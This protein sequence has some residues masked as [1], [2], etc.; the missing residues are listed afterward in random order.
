MKAN[1]IGIRILVDD[2]KKC[3]DFYHD[4]LGFEPNGEPGDIYVNF[5]T[6]N[7]TYFS[8]FRKQNN[9]LYEGYEDIGKQIKS[10]YVTL[11]L[12]VDEE[13]DIDGLYEELL[14]MGV[15]TIGAPRNMPQ[16]GFRCLWLRDPEGNMLEFGG[17]LK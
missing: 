8:M 3:Y 5:K 13:K 1:N 15:E 16:W 17:P 6:G 12:S 10:D 7:G 4:I 14:E 11:T 9:V 2:F